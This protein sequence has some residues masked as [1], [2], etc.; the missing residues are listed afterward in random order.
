M[1]IQQPIMLGQ[2]TEP[3]FT[4]DKAFAGAILDAVNV[5]L[6]EEDIPEGWASEQCWINLRIRRWTPVVNFHARL[7]RFMNSTAQLL[8]I[9]DNEEILIGEIMTCVDILLQK[10]S[11]EVESTVAF[12]GT[13]IG[14][15]GGLIAVA[16][17]I[18][19]A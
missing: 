1:I 7:T 3:L 6:A 13:V 5:L 10:E 19:I 15:L 8:Q 12:A 9:T 2:A 18:G 14:V 16:V 17:A 11:A 4:I